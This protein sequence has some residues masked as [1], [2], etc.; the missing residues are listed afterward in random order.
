MTVGCLC[1]L[2][3]LK[4]C[5]HAGIAG[6]HQ[7]INAG[8]ALHLV[9]EWLGQPSAPT[10]PAQGMGARPPHTMPQGYELA[11]WMQA[12]WPKSRPVLA[13][14]TIGNVKPW[15]HAAGQVAPRYCARVPLRT[16]LMALTRSTVARQLP[17]GYAPYCPGTSQG[18]GGLASL[19]QRLKP[20]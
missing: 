16:T 5:L 7:A 9:R 4:R 12:P 19:R 1:W 20:Y 10:T 17:V 13:V 15:S 8:L 11:L 6:A 14:F 2:T 18:R 3:A